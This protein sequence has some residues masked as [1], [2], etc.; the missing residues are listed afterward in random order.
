MNVLWNSLI[1]ATRDVNVNMLTPNSLDV[2]K[3][4]DMLTTLNLHQHVHRPIR[5]TP[6]SKTLID[7]IVT[8]LCATLSNYQ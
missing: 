8:C 4:I 6:T 7:H 3:Y 1:I 5:T 2:K